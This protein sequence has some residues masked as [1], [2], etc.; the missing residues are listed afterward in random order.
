MAFGDP[1]FNI[2]DKFKFVFN[3]KFAIIN[4]GD[5]RLN[6]SK[7]FSDDQGNLCYATIRSNSNKAYRVSIEQD[8]EEGN[9]PYNIDTPN[10]FF[11]LC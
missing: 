2:F 11:E 5:L 7:N 4:I 9:Y 6:Y 3:F 1:G 8:I 10:F